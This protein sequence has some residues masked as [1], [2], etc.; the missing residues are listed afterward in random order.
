MAN[1]QYVTLIEN[2]PALVDLLKYKLSISNKLL[3]KGLI[4]KEV[5]EYS[6]LTSGELDW[7]KASRLIS[8]VTDRVRHDDTGQLFFTF[9]DVLSEEPFFTEIVKKISKSYS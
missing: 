4:T 3:A 7:K 1:A 6:I 8:C 9:L 5:A 2:N